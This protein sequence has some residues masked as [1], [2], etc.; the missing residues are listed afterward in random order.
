MSN[1]SRIGQPG[2]PGKT[3]SPGQP[4]QP[5]KTGAP[6]Q[7][8]QPGKTG[9][10][11]QPGKI[12]IGYPGEPGERGLPGR[13][14]RHLPIINK[15]LYPSA[16]HY[17]KSVDNLRRLNLSSYT[18]FSENG[19]L[20]NEGI[21][22]FP[23]KKCVNF[24]DIKSI[25]INFY[26]I[27][28]ATFDLNLVFDNLNISYSLHTTLIPGKKYQAMTCCYDYQYDQEL[29]CLHKDNTKPN[30]DDINEINIEMNNGNIIIS[31]LTVI[32]KDSIV[33]FFLFNN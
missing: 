17:D 6:G 14:Y 21:I 19:W 10:P 23:V 22:K 8:G 28:A 33:N 13:D 1:Q 20:F 9:S 5:G 4:G 16:S 32:Y 7:P 3:G 29:V 12:G 18:I 27:T 25:M 2:Q 15:Y 30:C 11:G 26:T 24:D 31:S